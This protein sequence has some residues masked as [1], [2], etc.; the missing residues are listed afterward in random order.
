MPFITEELWQKLPHKG[1]SIMIT[2]WPL[3]G[4]R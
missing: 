2:N 4:S 1:D 3:V